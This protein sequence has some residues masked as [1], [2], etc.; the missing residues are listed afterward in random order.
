MPFT[1]RQSSFTSGVLDAGLFGRIDISAYSSGASKLDNVIPLLQGGVTVRSGTNMIADITNLLPPD[2]SPHDF[3]II[4]FEYAPGDSAV[5]VLS[6]KKATVYS[7][8]QKQAE[9]VLPYGVGDIASVNYS[10]SLDTIFLVHEK[11]PPAKMYRDRRSGVVQW[12][13]EVLSFTS[14]PSWGGNKGYPRGVALFQ[15]RLF[16]AGTPANPEK[17]WGSKSG[18]LFNF[19]KTDDAL[20]DEA[21]ETSVGSGLSASIRYLYSGQKLFALTDNGIFVFSGETVTPKKF[22]LERQSELSIGDVAPAELDQALVFIKRGGDNTHSSVYEALYNESNRVFMNTDLAPLSQSVIRRPKDMAVRHSSHISSA[23]SMF[24]VNGDGTVA[25]LTYL[26]N[27]KMRGWSVMKTAGRVHNVCHVDGDVYFIIER[28]F[29]KQKLVSLEKFSTKMRL[30]CARIIE[31]ASPSKTFQVDYLPDG[32]VVDVVVY[33]DEKK[34]STAYGYGKYT[35]KNRQITLPVAFKRIQVGVAFDW[36]VKTLPTYFDGGQFSTSVNRF[37]VRQVAVQL[38]NIRALNMNGKPVQLL[39]WGAGAYGT[40]PPLFSGLKNIKRTGYVK[41]ETGF[42][43]DFT[44]SSVHGGD[45]LSVE[46]LLDF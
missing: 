44:S 11:H 34:D 13:Y 42:T 29:N 26:R 43:I 38:Q 12:K 46:Q 15:E 4:A 8:G 30:D 37:R 18:D 27:E 14:S 16:F 40:I 1:H 31:K 41:Q 21:V 9:V 36:S 19:S 6:P 17:I 25:L 32:G 23:Y 33:A 45:I 7:S 39:R 35:I 3:R 20:D 24:V 22:W 10:N 5:V 2:G 28:E